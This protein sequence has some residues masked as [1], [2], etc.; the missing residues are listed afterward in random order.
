MSKITE[1]Y[2]KDISKHKIIKHPDLMALFKKY[3]NSKQPK[4]K[5]LLKNQIATANLR[6]VISEAKKYAF[7]GFSLDDL[8]QEGNIGLLRAIEMFDYK[9]GFRFSTY[10]RWWIKQSICRYL[11]SKSRTIRLPAHIVTAV[12]KLNKLLA[13]EHT[14]SNTGPS[15]TELSERLKMSKDLTSATHTATKGIVSL[16]VP[17][18]NRSGNNPNSKECTQDKLESNILNPFEQLNQKEMA[19]TIRQVLQKLNDKE[20]KV[21]RLRFGI[22]EDPNDHNSW[23]ITKSELNKIKNK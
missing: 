6:L 7:K 18:K 5:R 2:F 20:E 3:N 21:L 9:R 16:N 10:A 4:R 13:A 22:S 8:I 23:P 15:I 1:A 12:G 11:I 14:L 19:N 17:L